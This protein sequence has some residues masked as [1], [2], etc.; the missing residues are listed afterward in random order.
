MRLEPSL[1]MTPGGSLADIPDAVERKR[2]DQV[3]EEGILGTSSGTMYM[4]IPNTRVKQCLKVLLGK[5]PG[6]YNE[7]KKQVEKK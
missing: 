6:L 7:Q 3:P 4:E 5:H 1:N 2:K